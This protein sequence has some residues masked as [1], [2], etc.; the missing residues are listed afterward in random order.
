M[1]PLSALFQSIHKLVSLSNTLHHTPQRDMTTFANEGR[2][3]KRRKTY[4]WIAILLVIALGVGL[5]LFFSVPVF[6]SPGG[7]IGEP[8]SM[9]EEEEEEEAAAATGTTAE[10]LQAEIFPNDQDHAK[11]SLVGDQFED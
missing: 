5:V 3:P 10:E 4:W 8:T 11:K 7:G 1:Y 6:F 9:E 2:G